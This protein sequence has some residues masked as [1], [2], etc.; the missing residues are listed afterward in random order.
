MLE[1]FPQQLACAPALRPERR[2]AR[3]RDLMLHP[4]FQHSG[5]VGRG[6]VPATPRSQAGCPPMPRCAVRWCIA[7]SLHPGA[8]WCLVPRRE[9]DESTLKP[10]DEPAAARHRLS[11]LDHIQ[12]HNM[13]IT[14]TIVVITARFHREISRRSSGEMIET[15]MTH[16]CRRISLGSR[17]VNMQHDSR[18][19]AEDSTVK[20]QSSLKNAS[21]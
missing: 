3:V 19:P 20:R 21:G 18:H 5:P 10:H 12:I 11:C 1:A 13:N 7:R 2:A 6:D 17:R 9:F 15:L 14:F 8:A 4:R 16:E